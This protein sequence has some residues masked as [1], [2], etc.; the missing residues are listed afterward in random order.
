MRTAALALAAVFGLSSAAG[1]D[2][3]EYR[4]ALTPQL[5]AMQ[6]VRLFVRIKEEDGCSL[7]RDKLESGTRRLLNRAGLE[8]LEGFDPAQPDWP[9]LE[10]T[11][12]SDGLATVCFWYVGILLRAN[13][14]G[15]V[16]EGNH[17]YEYEEIWEVKDSGMGPS[18]GLAV[19][20]AKHLARRLTEMTADV[21]KA[22]ALYPDL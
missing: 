2:E 4:P 12:H 1:A 6:G 11:V 14:N 20:V 21:E 13:V 19:H 5:A 15:A 8:T 22:R 3:P 17:Y 10:V 9:I 7:L 18:N 16:V